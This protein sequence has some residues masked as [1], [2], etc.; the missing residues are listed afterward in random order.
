MLARCAALDQ[1]GVGDQPVT[2]RNLFDDIGIVARSAEPLV[3]HIDQS[4]MI[5][6]VETGVNQIGSVD[7]EDDEPRWA[8]SRAGRSLGH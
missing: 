2:K 8:V 4:D 1:N 3:D 7:V 5:D 6:T